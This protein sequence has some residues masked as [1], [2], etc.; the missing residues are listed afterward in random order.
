MRGGRQGDETDNTGD[1]W[2]GCLPNETDEA[3]VCRLGDPLTNCSHFADGV[4][5]PPGDVPSAVPCGC[6]PLWAVRDRVS[7]GGAVSGSR[8]LGLVQ[9]EG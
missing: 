8:W 4:S 6:V 3:V 5:I 2:T 1:D 9:N 7:T